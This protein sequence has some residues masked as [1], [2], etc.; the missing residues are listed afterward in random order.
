MRL[1]TVT[2][3]IFRAAGKKKKIKKMLKIKM[4][5]FITFLYRIMNLVHV[6]K[7]FHSRLSCSVIYFFR[8]NNIFENFTVSLKVFSN[9]S[10]VCISK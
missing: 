8:R 7:T 4:L 10:I 9:F 5:T 1:H 6:A 2:W 3:K